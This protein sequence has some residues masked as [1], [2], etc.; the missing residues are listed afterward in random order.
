MSNWSKVIQRANTDP[1]FR[2]QLKADPTAA[3]NEA[4]CPVPS[5][6]QVE[7]VDCQRGDLHL[8]LG[9]K[10]NVPEL[11]NLLARAGNDPAFKQELLNN[12]RSA[13]EAACG[14]KLPAK[15][16]VRIH[17]PAS[18]RVRLLLRRLCR[19][20]G[21]SATRNLRPLRAGVF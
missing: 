8:W 10:T 14:E 16:Q 19:S 17:E 4:G 7:V 15:C 21:N 13:V 1:E 9:S 2:S 18:E 3:C 6:T 11:D 5:G 12:P 20:M